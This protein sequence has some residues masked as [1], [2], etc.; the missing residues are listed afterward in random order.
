[1]C[2]ASWGSPRLPRVPRTKPLLDPA[3]RPCWATKPGTSATPSSVA[4]RNIV[5]AKGNPEVVPALSIKSARRRKCGSAT[6][7][8]RSR[9]ASSTPMCRRRRTAPST[10]A[11]CR[12]TAMGLVPARTRWSSSTRARATASKRGHVLAIW[13]QGGR[14][15]D[16]LE[17]KKTQLQLPDER[18]GLLMV[19]RPSTR[20]SYALIIT[21][22]V[23]V[24]IGDRVTSPDPPARHARQRRARELAPPARQPGTRRDGV[25]RLLAAFGSPE[26]IIQSSPRPA[27]RWSGPRR[28]RHAEPPPLDEPGRSTCGGGAP[29]A[30]HHVLTLADADYPAELLQ[31]A[32]PPLMLYL[33]GGSA[34][35]PSPARRRRQPQPDAAGPGQRARVR[36]RLRAANA[37]VVSGLALGVDGA[38]HEGALDA[39]ARR[40]AT[41]AVV[42]TGLDRVYPPPPA[43]GPPHRA[44]TVLVSANIR[45]A[46]RRCR[47]TFPQRNRIIAGLSPGHAGG[48]GGA[49]VG[50]ADHRAL[51]LPSGARRCSRSP[52]RS[53]RRSRAA[54]TRCSGRAPSWWRPRRTSSG[55]TA[56]LAAPPRATGCRRATPSGTPA[57]ADALLEALGFDPVSLDAL[58]ARTGWPGTCQCAACSNSN[59]PAR[60]ARLPGGLFHAA[61]ARLRQRQPAHRGRWVIVVSCSKCWS[62][63]TKTTGAPMPAPGSSSCRASSAPSRLRSD[64]I[65][66]ALLWLDG[67][68]RARE[69]PRT[70][71]RRA[72]QCLRRDPPRPSM[73][74]AR[75]Q[76]TWAR[77]PGLHQLPRILR[78]AAGAD[79]R[80]RDRPRDGRPRRRPGRRS[81]T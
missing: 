34:C 37:C 59:S 5:D 41:I 79:A 71:S 40:L 38:A 16:R 19:F 62:S 66:D 76:D 44:T 50:L 78:R 73:R 7:W 67:L 60:V 47:A 80:D 61:R 35:L 54:A 74:S 45:S 39:Q 52:A 72:P 8:C 10:V 36:P 22:N 46:R 15:V 31:T 27:D 58:I 32:D 53:I 11:S 69:S 13:R 68:N 17:D 4:G 63:S 51:A 9:R 29:H 1:M 81:T 26:A 42:G 25:R 20:L 49:A 14:A 77:V 55:G 70:G 6:A 23:Q 18:N 24:I 21:I 57:A 56:A 12:C 64:E 2:W 65:H 43:S 28:S 33:R 48:R 75:R 3:P 30:A